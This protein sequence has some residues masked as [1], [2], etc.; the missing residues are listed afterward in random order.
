MEPDVKLPRAPG[1]F[2]SQTKISKLP[3]FLEN[4]RR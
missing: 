1:K 3:P 2:E 4:S